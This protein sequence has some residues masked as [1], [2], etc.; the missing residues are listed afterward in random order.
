MVNVLIIRP[1]VIVYYFNSPTWSYVQRRYIKLCIQT[2]HR[3]DATVS[4][5]LVLTANAHVETEPHQ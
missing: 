3:T 1:T 4:A 5:Q 2:P